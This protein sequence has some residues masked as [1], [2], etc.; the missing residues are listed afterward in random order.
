V[1][2]APKENSHLARQ[3]SWFVVVVVVVVVIVAVL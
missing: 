3:I 2:V 1:A